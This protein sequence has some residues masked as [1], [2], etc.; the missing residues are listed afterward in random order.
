[1]SKQ[2]LTIKKLYAVDTGSGYLTTLICI[3]HFDM[4]AKVNGLVN[5][6]QVHVVY[7]YTVHVYG[8]VYKLC[9]CTLYIHVHV[10]LP[11][12]DCHSSMLNITSRL[13]IRLRYLPQWEFDWSDMQPQRSRESLNLSDVLPDERDAAE[14][15]TRAIQYVMR[16][17]VQEFSELHNL[18]QFAPEQQTL[19]PDV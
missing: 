15:K 12:I 10:C 13:A 6:V 14:L 17:L 5:Y 9:T 3:N 1:M 11:P 16:F 18:A 7:T 2:R 8:F 4:S 19:N